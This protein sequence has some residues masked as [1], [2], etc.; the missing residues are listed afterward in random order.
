MD[1]PHVGTCMHLLTSDGDLGSRCVGSRSVHPYEPMPGHSIARRRNGS[2]GTTVGALVLAS[3]PVR[4]TDR[5]YRDWCSKPKEGRYPRHESQQIEG[6][7]RRHDESA[8]SDRGCGSAQLP[9]AREVHVCVF[10][11]R[12]KVARVAWRVAYS[13]GS[14]WRELRRACRPRLRAE[15]PSA[16][17]TASEGFAPS[18]VAT[19]KRNSHLTP[20]ARPVRSPTRPHPPDLEKPITGHHQ[21]VH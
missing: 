2:R 20:N 18:E 3:S 1:C 11:V 15:A 10:R 7:G 21:L 9:S 8:R 14:V 4:T 17:L 12:L 13:H 5:A 6:M 19:T 16:P